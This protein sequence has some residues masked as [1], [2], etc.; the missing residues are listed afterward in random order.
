MFARRTDLPLDRDTLSQ[1][2]PWLIAFMVYLASLALAGI[3]IFGAMADRWNAGVSDTLTVQ[4]APAG[5][6]ESPAALDRRAKAAL[7]LLRKTDGVALA[8]PVE[9]ARILALLEPWLGPLGSA[10]DLPLPRLIDVQVGPGSDID[11]KDLARRLDVVSPGAT[12]DDNGVW[13]DRFVRLLR[14]VEAVAFLVLALIGSVTVGTVVFTTRTGLS[15]HQDAIEVLHLIGAQDAYIA[16]Q[17][18]SRAFS[19]GLKGGLIGLGLAAPTLFGI[20]WLAERMRSNLLPDEGL[21]G[22][23]WL[24]LALLPVAVAGIA[25]VTAR[26]TVLRNLR[27]ML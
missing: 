10:E 26:L 15:I 6:G 19:L 2:L 20:G 12:V 11:I 7:D 3:L 18:A 23:Q 25:M 16:R 21:G 8:E 24:I 1:F 17:F 14:T 4:I 9:E 22:A 5:N 13:L 27:R